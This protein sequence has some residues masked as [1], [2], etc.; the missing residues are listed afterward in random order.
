MTIITVAASASGKVI[1]LLLL[2][3]MVLLLLL[4]LLKEE[5][6][7]S[8]T[9]DT[10]SASRAIVDSRVKT[11]TKARFHVV[12]YYSLVHYVNKVRSGTWYIIRKFH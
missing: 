9:D 6:N 7:V 5:T 12:F 1:M 2:A 4:L 11:T 8:A 3:A 10:A